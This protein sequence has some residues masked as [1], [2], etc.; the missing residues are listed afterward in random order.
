MTNETIHSEGAETVRM[1]TRLPMTYLIAVLV[2]A[3]VL[4]E[5]S[6]PGGFA[7]SQ[8]KPGDFLALSSVPSTSTLE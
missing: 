7:R 2:L 1:R 3:R 4:W 5:M 8:G 6:S